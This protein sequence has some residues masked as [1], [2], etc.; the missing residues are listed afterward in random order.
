MLDNQPNAQDFLNAGHTEW[1]LQNIK[2]ALNYYQQVV[3]MEEGNFN[4]FQELFDQ[5][6][7]ELIIA[8]IE[9]SEIILMLDQLK[10]QIGGNS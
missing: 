3:K 4:K 5:D 1:A 7:E 10:Y 9:Q 6:V 8:G 2:G